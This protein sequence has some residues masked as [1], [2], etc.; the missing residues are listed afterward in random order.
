M[1]SL[2]SPMSLGAGSADVC[3]VFTSATIHVL[4]RRVFDPAPNEGYMRLSNLPISRKIA[5]AF[6]LVLCA[7]VITSAILFV[8]LRSVNSA[9]NIARDARLLIADLDRAVDSVSEQTEDVR[10][11]LM[12]LSNDPVNA[13]HAAVQRFTDNLADART[14]AAGHAGGDAIV[15]LIDKV[16][17]A[18]NDWRKAVTDLQLK[19]AEDPASFERAFNVPV[20]PPALLRMS[21]FRK[22]VTAARSQIDAWS[23]ATSAAAEQQLA[24]SQMVQL[25]GGLAAALIATLV[26]WALAAAIAR[27]VRQ[28]TGVMKKLAE[29]DNSVEVPA[30]GRCDEIGSMASAVE[31]FKEAAIERVRLETQAARTALAVEQERAARMTEQ[32]RDALD[33]E[34]SI[35]ALGNALERLAEGDLVYRIETPFASRFEKLRTD[36]NSSMEKLEEIMGAIASSFQS[37]HAGAQEMSSV[38]GNLS[39][40]TEQQAATLEETAA[41]LQEITTTVKDTAAAVAHANKVVA[42]AG[43]DAEMSGKVVRETIAAMDEIDKSSKQIGQIIGVIDEIAFQTNLLALNAG[44]EAA[45]AGDSGRGFAVVASEVRALAERST[46]AAKEVKRLISASLAQ[47]GKGV[48]LVGKTG[49]ALQRIV[50]EVAQINGIVSGIASRSHEQSSSLV[51][52][53]AAISQMDDVTQQNAAM[54]EESAGA[55][56]E[57]ARSAED[58]ARMIDRFKLSSTVTDP[59]ETE[60][61]ADADDDWRST[62]IEANV[63]RLNELARSTS[64]HGGYG[65]SRTTAR[66]GASS[67]AL[68][69]AQ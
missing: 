66:R 7:T 56:Q 47:V 38:A 50:D 45:R 63:R 43:T 37:I 68:A 16:D 62:S 19:L 25:L 15:A 57:L 61:T 67:R 39:S 59:V 24:M 10:D 53:N 64:A 60:E 51:N 65:A 46:Q 33:A 3:S 31:T 18:G 12:T 23:D 13:Y 28:M 30:V 36:F 40:R 54:V 4:W 55:S 2:V 26:G 32:E 1:P 17:A 11:H 69:P 21:E 44:V 8:S 52:I 41:S 6:G 14:R 58:L 22:A 27:P 48:D 49:Q 42:G 5:L 29:G 35:G 34:Q 20:S 9:E